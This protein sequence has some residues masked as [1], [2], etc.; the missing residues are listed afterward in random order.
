MQDADILTAVLPSP[1]HHRQEAVGP[2][3]RRGVVHRAPSADGA[4][5]AA[6]GGGGGSRRAP[7]QGGG[8]DGDGGGRRRRG[9]GLV[10]VQV[11][12]DLLRW[13]LNQ[14]HPFFQEEV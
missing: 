7:D 2:T 12:A 5:A 4:S 14:R 13:R 11:R 8:Q 6:A 1:Q 3:G 9:F 10:S